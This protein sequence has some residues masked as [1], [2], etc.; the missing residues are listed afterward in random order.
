[1]FIFLLFDGHFFIVESIQER[2]TVVNNS[3]TTKCDRGIF[4][5]T[6]SQKREMVKREMDNFKKNGA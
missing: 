6:F 5:N 1:M 2:L 3:G 4:S